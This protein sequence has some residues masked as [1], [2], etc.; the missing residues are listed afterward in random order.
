[1]NNLDKCP[2]C[3]AKLMDNLQEYACGFGT[4]EGATQF[5]L[6]RERELRQKEAAE[7]QKLR[8]LLVESL[9]IEPHW[10]SGQEKQK[11]IRAQLEFLTPTKQ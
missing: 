8:E 10:L 4:E 11:L 6:C 7:N 9:S 1:M 3:G 5:P 2:H